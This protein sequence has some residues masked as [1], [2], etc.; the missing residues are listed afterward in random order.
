M[1][2][3]SAVSILGLLV[4]MAV[5]L[6][7]SGGSDDESTAA[8]EFK[9]HDDL[10][11]DINKR[12]PEFGGMSLSEDNET[13]YVYVTQD[14]EYTLNTEAVKRTIKDVIK[15]DP[16]R[17]R[18]LR[19]IPAKYSMLRLYEWYDQ[20]QDVVWRNPNVVLTDLEEGKNRIEIGVNSSD[21]IKK[22][23]TSL[24]SLSI[25][26]DAIVVHV[27][28]LPVPESHTL[29]DR[30]PSG[31][32]EGG[33][34]IARRISQTREYTC[35]LGFN[36]IRSGDAGFVTNGHCTESNWDGGV[37]GTDFY[38]PSISNSA[39]LIGEETIDPTFSSS[40]SGCG[41]GKVC[42]WSDSAFVELSSGVSQNLGKIAKT[43]LGST[44]VIH[45]S[46]YRIV[47]AGSL[48]TIGEYVHKVG[49][50]T[51][52][53]RARVTDTCENIIASGNRQ[54][55]CQ[56][57]ASLT[58]GS[59]ASGDSGAPVFRVTNSPNRD[60]VELLGIHRGSVGASIYFSPMIN[61]YTDL[62][63]STTWKV[64]DPS[65]RC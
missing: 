45:S 20:A 55:L 64:C 37:D 39:N 19:L 49:K 3:I 36:A 16:T 22:V 57:V 15:A 40:L 26:S 28:E 29:E 27:R 53:S 18:A 60:D 24:A 23:E 44:T 38:Q 33:Y 6:A 56:A 43:G 17:G 63:L 1:K 65:Y 11:L 10:L 7:S 12:V 32:I 13:L 54:L 31:V 50:E 58:G 14:S 47:G 34:E 62:G 30:A 4:V 35:T 41:H 59:S 51:G 52:R 48:P 61:I 9:T 46:K 2:M 5:T 8:A 25:P 42:R 21:A